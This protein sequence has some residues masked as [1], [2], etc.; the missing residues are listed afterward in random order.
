MSIGFNEFMLMLKPAVVLLF[1]VALKFP[2][3][4][5]LNRKLVGYSFVLINGD[6]RDVV[7][8]GGRLLNI[9]VYS[10][11]VFETRFRKYRFRSQKYSL[12]C[13]RGVMNLK[14]TIQHFHNC[15]TF[16]PWSCR[17]Q[18]VGTNQ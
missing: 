5:L 17:R 13:N 10:R 3:D 15:K 6:V 18:C 14:Y 16:L 11:L 1:F 8:A 7:Y 4:S 12:L 2:E 9:A